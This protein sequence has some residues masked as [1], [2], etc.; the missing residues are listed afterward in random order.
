MIITPELDKQEVIYEVIETP[1][2]TKKSA[3]IQFRQ[4]FEEKYKQ[5][6]C[7]INTTASLV[8]KRKTTAKFECYQ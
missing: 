4:S 1:K 5:L 2:F 6:V 7:A 3:E 8:E